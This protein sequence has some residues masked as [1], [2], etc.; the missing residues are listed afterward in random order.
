MT[1]HRMSKHKQGKERILALRQPAQCG[2]SE[3]GM[4]EEAF[5]SV[6]WPDAGCQSMS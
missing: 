3:P 1:Q 2:L 6:G 5:C 4:V